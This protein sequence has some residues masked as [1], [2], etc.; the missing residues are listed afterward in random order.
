LLQSPCNTKNQRPSSAFSRQISAK[1][2][3]RTISEILV[4]PESVFIHDKLKF[5]KKSVFIYLSRRFKTAA[6]RPRMKAVGIPPEGQEA[7]KLQA[8]A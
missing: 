4:K 2:K 1:P 3:N 8:S 6:L 5:L 7:E